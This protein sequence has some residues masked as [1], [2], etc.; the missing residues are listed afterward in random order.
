L[1]DI[2]KLQDALACWRSTPARLLAALGFEPVRLRVP[3]SALA[4][5][6]LDP[7]EPLTLEVAARCA[8][9][10]V[11]RIILERRLDPQAI[12]GVATALYR[13]NPTRRALLIFEAQVGGRLVLASWGLGSGPFRLLKLWIDPAAPRRSELDILAGLAA[14][15]AA[16]ASDL[17][18]AHARALDREG[19]TRRFFA[20]FR[21]H[22]AEVAAGLTGVPESAGQDR[23][24]LALTLLSRLLFLYF[25]QRKG[26][27]AGDTAYLRHLYEDSLSHG[28]PFYRQRLKHLFFS[29]LNRAPERRGR[30]AQ[31]LGELP[32][33]NGGL[34]ERD[35]LERKYRRLDVP[36]ECFAPIFHELLDKYQFTLRED[37]PADQDVAVDPEMLGRVF[38]GLMAEPLRGSTGAFFTPRALVA[39][40]VDGALVAYLAAATDCDADTIEGLLAGS[41]LHIEPWLHDRLTARVRTIRVLDPAVGSGAFLLAVLQRLEVLRDALEG[42]PADSFARFQRRQEMIRRNLHGVDINGAAVRLCELRLWLALSVDLEV[43]TVADVPPLPN[44]DINIRQG[45]A[46]IDPIDF[47]LQ[48]ADLDHGQLA[49]RWQRKVTRL[50]GRRDRYF[51]SAGA[52]KRR[53]QRSL[54]RA[55]RDLALSFLGELAAQ[56]DARRQ[57]LRMAARG[58]DLFGKRAGLTRSQKRA[59]ATLKRRKSEVLRLLRRISEAEELPFFS[60]PI[61]FADRETASAN[62]HIVLGNPPWV[63]THHWSGLSRRL[64]SE[65]FQ[66]LRDAGWRTG[67][68]LAGAGRGFGAQLDLS[69]LFLERALGVLAENG[70]LGFLLPA[71]LARGLSAGALRRRLLAF[72]QILQLE[73]C[74]LATARLFEATTYP[75]GLIVK[76]EEPCPQHQVSVRL[77]DRQGGT[78]DF[79]LPQA[80]LPL[81]A[82]DPESPWV[83]AP[84]AVRAALER[85][86]AAGPPL[87]SQP[88]RR[89]LRGIVTGNNALFVGELLTATARRGRAA[90][91]LGSKGVLIE[92]DRLRPA[93]R[94]EDLAP[95]RFSVDRAL[96]WTHDDEGRVL[97]SLPTATRRYVRMHERAL[98]ERIDLKPGQLFWTLFRVCPQKWGLRVA[99]R[100]IAP[101]PGAVVV[102]PQAPFLGGLAPIIS[103]NTVYQVSAAS[104]EDAYL[105]AAV[106]NSTVARAYL[107]A[108]AER[109]AG[110]YFRYLGWTVALLPFPEKADAAVLKQLM[111]L[112]KRAH[113]AGGLDADGQAELDQLVARLYRLEPSEL[114]EL[115][116]FDARLLNPCSEA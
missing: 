15:G 51:H 2:R 46:L 10:Q 98:K 78:L 17:A 60:F 3:D 66:F 86:R 50:A 99:W 34:F 93:L 90:L 113:S 33:L 65:R 4:D 39:R 5:F 85:M 38:E 102:P 49:G 44:L 84:P 7:S 8:G 43:E 108:I 96:V 56:I 26:W 35:V 71:K 13:H 94:G 23:L 54:R 115:R 70:A 110:G 27:L 76:R 103:L 55:E 97:A 112:S 30:Q 36:D 6:G 19:V 58:R 21:R 67:T 20:E 82:E 73:D 75:L 116:A 111:Q 14:D 63:R 28:V 104:E 92:A 9:F 31:Q 57:D 48:L 87:G 69:A 16:T 64:L 24:D 32:Y 41:S 11:L 42:R 52:D 109:A 40:L 25:I 95:W 107:K 105:V 91:R 77:H 80:R 59:A 106:L 74:S 22:R 37:Q 89:P 72:T 47:L 83:L 100:D 79:R 45:D 68:R 61:H 1:V 81:I 29:A 18:L 62:F 53:A 114:E 88:G 101:A 12:R